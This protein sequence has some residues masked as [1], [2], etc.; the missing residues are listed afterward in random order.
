[1]TVSLSDGLGLTAQE[2]TDSRRA[3]RMPPPGRSGAEVPIRMAGL[4]SRREEVTQVQSFL[5]RQRRNASV[6]RMLT[7]LGSHPLEVLLSV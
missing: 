4:L 5:V 7:L 2:G 6:L 3:Q 1:M